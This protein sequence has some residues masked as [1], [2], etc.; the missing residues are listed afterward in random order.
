MGYFWTA[1]MGHLYGQF[2]K[3]FGNSIHFIPGVKNLI[4][5]CVSFRFVSEKY[6]FRF[7]FRFRFQKKYRFVSFRFVP[8][9]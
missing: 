3:L 7:G 1:H 2:Q 6:L 8:V 4:F 5:F 9:K